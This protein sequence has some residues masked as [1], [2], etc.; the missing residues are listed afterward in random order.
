MKKFLKPIISIFSFVLLLVLDLVTKAVFEAK[1]ITLIK[2]VFSIF[3]THNT[4]AGFSIFSNQ[5]TFLLIVTSVFLVLFTLFLVFEKDRK[6][7]L[8]WISIALIY[9]GAIGNMI[10]RLMFGYVRDF[11]YF[12]LINFPIFNVADVCLTVG[13]V[14]FAIN[15]LFLQP[16]LNK[17]DKNNG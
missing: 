12:E 8:W 3:S 16:K 7:N 13:I 17:G 14:L 1:N 2:G 15:F 11:L 9:S 6:T 5:T 4:G 10:D